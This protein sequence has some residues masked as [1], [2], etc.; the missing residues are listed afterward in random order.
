MPVL[1]IDPEYGYV[2]LTATATAFV[3]T[4]MGFRVGGARK[5][6]GVQYPKLYADA[7]DCGGKQQDI[8]TFNCIQRAHQNSLENLPQFLALLVFGGANYPA[9]AALAGVIYLAGRVAYVLGYSTGDPKKRN[10]GAFG[11]IGLLTLVG[12]NVH[13]GLAL[14]QSH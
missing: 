10:W 4:W 6:Y 14:L 11:Y 3:F 8:N 13:T 12:L 2:V 7:S 1:K 5:K 9:I